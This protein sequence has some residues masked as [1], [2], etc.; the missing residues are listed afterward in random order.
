MFKFFNFSIKFIIIFSV[1]LLLFTFSTF[2]YFSIGLPD[3]KKL[4]NFERIK[5]ELN[6]SVPP[7]SITVL[8]DTTY[9]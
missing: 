2:W 5:L 7:F 4:S 9:D 8:P 6:A 1:T 3:Y